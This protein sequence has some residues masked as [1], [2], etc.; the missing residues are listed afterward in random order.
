M[1]KYSIIT[2]AGIMVLISV[3]AFSQHGGHGVSKHASETAYVSL[4]DA[5]HTTSIGKDLVVTYDFDKK[6]SMGMVIVKLRI[7]NKKGDRVT[8][9][10]V[11]G[12]SGMPSMRGAHDSGETLFKLNRKG[13]YL[14][15]VNVVMP[16]DWEI[17]V[18]FI[19]DKKVLY[20]GVIR[21]DV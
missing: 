13:D 1:M 8:S 6:P 18:K 10:K 16:G 7:F 19:R 15:P 17:K 14:L 12:D 9:L 20:R 11:T 21:F 3:Y 5:G 4:G 2:A